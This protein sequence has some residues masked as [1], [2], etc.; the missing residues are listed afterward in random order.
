[1]SQLLSFY[2]RECPHCQTMEPLVDRLEKELEVAVERLEVWHD[3]DNKDTLEA[4]DKGVCG[5]V[6]YFY[7]TET[8][9]SICGEASYEELKAWALGQAQ[10]E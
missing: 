10:G 5:G 2:G 3:D 1:M 8:K 9:G 6:P 7:N 4:Y